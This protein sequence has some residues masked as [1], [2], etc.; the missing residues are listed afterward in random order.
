MPTLKITR[1]HQGVVQ[2]GGNKGKL[3]K[4]YKYSGKK[5]NKK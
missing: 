3:K 4:G 2:T 1:K 5:N